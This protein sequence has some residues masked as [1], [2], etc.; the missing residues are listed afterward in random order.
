MGAV[1]L[2]NNKLLLPK[3]LN[4]LPLPR[5]LYYST[6]SLSLGA[7]VPTP[8][9]VLISDTCLT[10]STLV[11]ADAQRQRRVVGVCHNSKF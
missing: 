4:K 3:F 10:R 5:F 1:S 2:F 8:V 7:R 9:F 11:T 6:Y